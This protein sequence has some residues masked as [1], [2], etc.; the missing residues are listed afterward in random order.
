MDTLLKASDLDALTQCDRKV[1]LEYHGDPALRLAP[2]SFDRWLMERGKAYEAEVASGFEWQRPHYSFENLEAGF[3]AT[4]SL[5]RQGVEAIYQ[6]VLIHAD[7]VGIPDLLLRV[8][9]ASR[10]GS[11]HYRPIDV[12]LSSTIKEGHRL[13]LMAYIWLLEQLQG[14][15]PDGFLFHRPPADERTPDR[16]YAEAIVA[17]DKDNFLE[18]L[19]GVRRLAS[20]Q[21]PRPFISSV[22][23]SCPWRDLDVPTAEHSQDVSLVP[24]LRR[25]VWQAL[26]ERGLGTLHAV[27]ATS[28]ERLIAIRNVGQK[29]AP[30]IVQQA[31][32]LM[33]SQPILLAKPNLPEPCQDEIF[34]DIEGITLEQVTY[35]V[36]ML[37]WQDGQLVFTYDLAEDPE[38]EGAMWQSFLQRMAEDSGPIY[39]YGFYEP[40]TIKRLASRYG[41]NAQMQAILNRLID[42]RSILTES[43]VLPLRSYSLKSV[44]PW[45]GFEWRGETQAADDS[46]LEYLAWLEDGNKQHLDHILQYN[47]EDCRAL[48]VVREWLRSLAEG[49]SSATKT[50]N[51]S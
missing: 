20:G 49:N 25:D 46:M 39:H 9:G 21:E 7:L 23:A 48:V 14:F 47:E 16:L 12:K 24:G 50:D 44:A 13:Q 6:G 43:I 1:Y 36:G 4:L 28:P 33:K 32:A 34:L 18:K 38:K 17:F 19:A 31:R 41:G 35:L 5:M 22:C 15:R 40:T 30:R 37:V 29:T 2:T 51:T 8:E 3:I 45:L 42:L 11:Y 10:L 27:A 26:H